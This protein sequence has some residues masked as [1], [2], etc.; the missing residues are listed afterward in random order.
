MTSRPL[1]SLVISALIFAGPG[2]G[3]T[4]EKNLRLPVIVTGYRGFSKQTLKQAEVEAGKIFAQIGI[5][6]QW[7]EMQS[8]A[9]SNQSSDVGTGLNLRIVSDTAA[10]AVSKHGLALTHWGDGSPATAVVFLDRTTKLAEVSR[11][12]LEIVLGCAIAHELGHALLQSPTH[13]RVGLMRRSWTVDDLKKAR[14]G[15]LGFTNDQAIRQA[16]ERFVAA[17]DPAGS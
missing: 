4:R 11:V 1:L 9:A 6:V 8:E 2:A 10:A 7:L 3:G 15:L 13:S 16:V 14:H 12:P 5:T 17:G